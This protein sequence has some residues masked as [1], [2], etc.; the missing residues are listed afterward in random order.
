MERQLI[1]ASLAVSFLAAAVNASEIGY[2]SQPALHSDRLV[3]VSE[4]DLWT[5]RIPETNTAAPIIAY[6]LTS[7]DG[8][9]YLPQI[10]PDGGQIAFA[11]Q[12][13]GNTDVY[14]MPIDGGAPTRL[15]FH[16][17]ADEPLAWT[18]DG[19]RIL[20]R[21]SR[22]HPLGRAELW[23]ISASGGMPTRYGFG[24][25]SMISLSPGGSRFAFTRWSNENWSWKRYRGGTA[26]EI[27]LGD[28]TTG[29]YA[30][31]TDDVAND[32]FPMWMMGRVFFLSDRT[33]TANIFSD[34]SQGGDV[35][36]HT[37]FAPRENVPA[38]IE[39]YDV[40][41]PA[42]DVQR[43]GRHIVFCQAGGL[44][45]LDITDNTIRRLNVKLASDRVAT[46]RRMTD[47]TEMM[48]EY[49]LSPDGETL[50]IGSRGELSAISMESGQ[51]RQLTRSSDVRD[52][53][54]AYVGE[55]QIVLITDMGGQQQIAAMPADGSDGPGLITEDREVWLFPLATSPDG[56][57]AAFGDKTMR[58]HTL[59]MITLGRRQVDQ[60][61]AGE[62][63]DYRFSP[64]SQWLAYTMLMPNG[65]GRIF[66]HSLRTGRSFAVSDD[67]HSDREPRWDPAGKYLYFLSQRHLN[68]VMGAF[69]FEHIYANTTGIYAVPLAEATPPPSPDAARAAGFDLE[70]WAKGD[71]EAEKKPAAGEGEVPVE[72]QPQPGDG[73][74]VQPMQV[75]VEGIAG[76]VYALPIEAGTYEQLEALPGAVTY[77]SNDVEGLLDEVW[78]PPA[79]GVGEGKLHRFN[80]VEEEDKVI[81]EKVGSYA[82]NQ[83]KTVIVFP[84]K[85]G[86]AKIDLKSEPKP[87]PVKIVK[88]QLRVDIQAEWK[89]IFDEAWRLQR[90]FYWAPNHTGVDWPAMYEKYQALLPRIGTR[91]ELNDLIGQMIGELSNSHTYVWGGEEQDNIEPVSVGMLGA[92]IE[93]DGGLFKIARIIPGRPGD[94]RLTSPLEAPYLPVSEGD[95]IL[96]IN[97][98]PLMLNSNIYDLLQD[99]AGKTV[100]L[101]IAD[102]DGRTNRRTVEVKALGSESG[103]RYAAWVEANRQYVA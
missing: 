65:Y 90:D 100:R 97:D 1:I 2:Y 82:I 34:A 76:R 77:V 60:A 92:D 38:A 8:S 63:T 59:N 62:I 10:S 64:D 17:S 14:V 81:A 58:L 26:P 101:A 50:L 80:V 15:T 35:E 39:G 3:F 28:F 79:A 93:L 19:R 36:Q 22:A 70:A 11:G 41:W 75:D 25:C 67:L 95:V 33:G 85:D 18:P 74:A 89:Q 42:A 16:P 12:Y 98:V 46:R 61:E 71:G 57:W 40:R 7:S 103:L 66:I 86:F 94:E 44:A 21:S 6:R 13:D 24:P 88:T 83:G 9:E 96:K 69:D 37:T 84:T 52:W 20:F 47:P 99:Q 43:R 31:L 32:L 55:D 27:W 54:A 49:T 102:A 30:P 78:P 29:T 23:R 4:G 91:G 73:E 51:V 48:T 72:A 87:E 45:L 56:Q 53:G 68:P 5:A